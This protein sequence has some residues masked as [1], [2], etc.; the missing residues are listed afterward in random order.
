MMAELNW[1]VFK[2]LTGSARDNW[3]LLCRELIRRNHSKDGHFRSVLQ[4]PG[5]EFHLKVQNECDLGDSSRHWGW[6]CRWYDLEAG[7]IG[8]NRRNKIVDALEK[9]KK[10]VPGITD[11]VLWTRR[12]LTPS[13]QE[14]YDALDFPYTLHH[15]AEEELTGLLTG[16]AEVLRATYFGELVLTQEKFQQMHEIAMAPI[17][18]RW[19][20]DLHIE[21]EV[22]GEL[23]AAFGSPGTW[24]AISVTSTRLAEHAREIESE[25]TGLRPEETELAEQAA[26]ALE[27]QSEHLNDLAAVLD[28]GSISSVRHCLTK[29]VNPSFSPHSITKLGVTLRSIK[30]PASIAISETNSELK[31]YFSLVGQLSSSL[32]ENFFAVIGDAGFGKTYL[33]AQ[34]TQPSDVSVGG[35]LLQAKYL[36]KGGTLDDLARRIPFGGNRMEQLLEAVDAAG[37]R[38]DCRIPIVIDGLNE[39][40]NPRD[41][42]DLLET[43]KVL[44]A[45]TSNCAV[46]VTLR[47]AVA[48]HILPSDIGK[49]YL[50]GFEYVMEE[51]VRKYFEYFKIDA[52]GAQLPWDKLSSP[53]FLSLFC[54][55][56][57]PDRKKTVGADRIPGSLTAILELY[58]NVV[59]SRAATVLN[60]THQDVESALEN[61]A[62]ALWDDN[63][64]GLNFD[65]L[66]ELVGDN[67]REWESSLAR[68][69][70]EEGVL[71]RDQGPKFMGFNPEMQTGENQVSAILYDAF[72]G[73][74]IADA[75]LA[76]QGRAGF[77]NWM[78]GNWKRLKKSEEGCHPLSED[79]FNAMVGLFPRRHRLQL[80]TI[81]PSELKE[82][83]LLET[84][85]LEPERIDESTRTELATLCRT[86]PS[87]GKTDPFFK[88]WSMRGAVQH[89]LNAD[90]L[91]KVLL[92][93]EVAHRDLRWSEWLR[94]NRENIVEDLERLEKRWAGNANRNDRDV[95]RARWVL[96]TLT[97]SVRCLRDQATRTL[98][99]YGIGA[100]RQ[101]FD[102]VLESF[103]INDPYV[104]ERA[105]AAAYGVVMGFQSKPA[106][107]FVSLSYLIGELA[108]RITGDDAS[109][110]TNY[111]MTR[112][113]IQGIVDFAR[114]FCPDALPDGITTADGT[115]VFKPAEYVSSESVIHSYSGYI[116]N[117]FENYEVGRLFDDRSNY[118]DQHEGFIAAIKEIRGRVWALGYRKSDFEM[119]DSEIGSDNRRRGEHGRTD[120]YA[121]KYGWI[122]YYEKAGNMSDTGTLCHKPRSAQGNPIVDIDPSFPQIP[123]PLSIVVPDWLS[124]GKEDNKEW[125]STGEVEVPD[126]LIRVA[127]IDGEEGPWIA[128]QGF[129]EQTNR[130]IGRQT[131][132]FI[133]GILAT[134][135]EVAK[136]VSLLESEDYLGNDFIP[137]EPSDYYTYAGEIP[138]SNG[139][140]NM[141]ECEEDFGLY[142]GRLGGSWGTGPVVEILS[143]HHAW[144]DYHSQMNRAGGRSVVSKVFSQQ[145][146]LRGAPSSF[147]Q[148]D[149][150]GKLAV[151]SRSPPKIC[152][153][154]GGLLYVREDL[155]SEYQTITGT[156]L[157]AA[158][159]GERN[160]INLGY[161]YPEWCQE[162]FQRYDHLWRRIVV[163]SDLLEQAVE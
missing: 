28:S 96:W 14:W 6:Q 141:D 145:F 34:L 116:G 94:K 99:W 5:I 66:R 106:D 69:L 38:L 89:P 111:W 84:T 39:S 51:A 75:I 95:L 2:S 27:E 133:R 8:N 136:V 54:Q 36:P 60:L 10:H 74:I 47:S 3:E 30:H 53:L 121:K 151:I 102:L 127:T 117:D 67:P 26:K 49:K 40:Q 123:V 32:E 18:H 161:G 108:N 25:S 44:L 7:Q 144:E 29:A 71:S 81:A 83:A 57:N 86:I 59:V 92:G 11:W 56:I 1:D 142:K 37:A 23:K 122:G 20:P 82:H 9:T 155:L 33:A 85:H 52:T 19:E 58:R 114:T 105:L 153:R 72:A 46:V 160:L 100:P 112:V 147:D 13:D 61:V 31:S 12:R 15:W 139:F 68:V 107:A 103:E 120:R 97:S 131:F 104:C 43:L 156:V 64:R 130:I 132:G 98:Y 4:Q 134:K 63:A 55:S 42:K 24:S 22:E 135:E 73:F 16:R 158:V 146:N 62:I 163:V 152:D 93:M 17:K 79:V 143:H 76:E 124:G 129:I 140:A 113:Y 128:V 90:F 126:G 48:D 65:K 77:V 45:A 157:I 91:H 149:A 110:P 87:F 101:C 70:E 125:L 119:A 109:S 41:W 137:S 50:S 78:A 118:D 88:L 148:Y 138:W 21:V 80:W 162:V 159:W 35:I 150:A 115:V 154:D